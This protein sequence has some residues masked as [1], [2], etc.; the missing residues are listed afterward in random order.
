MTPPPPPSHTLPCLLFNRSSAVSPSPRL[1]LSNSIHGLTCC[2]V[3]YSVYHSFIHSYIGT[4]T[5]R[6]IPARKVKAEYR[7]HPQPCLSAP[8]SR[9]SYQSPSHGGQN[10]THA[11]VSARQG[12]EREHPLERSQ[13]GGRSVILLGKKSIRRQER[14]PTRK[15]VSQEAGA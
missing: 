10:N 15:E 1:A 4:C 9:P 11:A 14:E 2:A 13:S 7:S 5:Q 3:S 6:S 8:C 12:Q